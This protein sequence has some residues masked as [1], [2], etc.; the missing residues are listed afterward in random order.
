MR[1]NNR[2][3]PLVQQNTVVVCTMMRC[4]II[5]APLKHPILNGPDLCFS[6]VFVVPR[7]LLQIH[8]SDSLS[9]PKINAC[10]RRRFYLRDRQVPTT[11]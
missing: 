5:G 6:L 8:F 2:K 1:L 9:N 4:E 3:K 10:L 11:K 7:S